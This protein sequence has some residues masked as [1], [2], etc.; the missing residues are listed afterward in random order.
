[1]SIKIRAPGKLI[2]LGEYAVLEGAN[3]LVASVDRYIFAEISASKNEYCHL[4]SNLTTDVIRF[5]SGSDG[6]IIPAQGQSNQLLSIMDFSLKIITQINKKIIDLGFSIQPYDLR[7]D[8]SQFYLETNKNK[9]GLGSSAAL[10]VA[11][12]VSISNFLKIE[13]NV[14]PSKYDQFIFACETHFFAQGNRG[15]G[16]DIAASVY[17]GINIYNIESKDHKKENRRISPVSLI[18]E[19]L[20]L[21]VWTGVSTSTRDLLHQLENFRSIAEDD[22]EETMSRL[23]TLSNSGC[24]TYVEKN[25]ADFLDIVRDYYQVLKNFTDR[26]KIDII[27][28]IHKKIAGIVFSNGGVYKPSGAGGGDIGI[29]MSDSK[30]TLE[31]IKKELALNNIYTLPLGISPQGVTIES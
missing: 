17:G 13:K 2:L 20:I 10:T 24:M 9:L 23:S 12:I 31:I 27:S 16:I 30:I 4:S 29:A 19:L 3:A 15:S 26:S 6:E 18:K 7:I 21:P 22:Y 8:S 11:L 28:D 1:L 25:Y 14:F 5:L